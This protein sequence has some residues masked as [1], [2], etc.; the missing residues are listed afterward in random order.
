MAKSRWL[1]RLEGREFDF[2]ALA[3]FLGSGSIRITQEDDGGW[4][5]CGPASDVPEGS[6]SVR[7]RGTEAVELLNNAGILCNVEKIKQGWQFG[8]RT[9]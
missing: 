7:D 6:S 3:E 5:L 2:E 8:R 9:H 4:H 1:I